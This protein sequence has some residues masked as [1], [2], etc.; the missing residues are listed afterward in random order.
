M[1]KITRPCLVPKL[2]A[3]SVFPPTPSWLSHITSFY[4]FTFQ[5]PAAGFK[6]VRGGRR[7]TCY[8]MWSLHLLPCA[9]AIDVT[10]MLKYG[11]KSFPTTIKTSLPE[12]YSISSTAT[13]NLIKF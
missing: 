13:F 6:E 9:V 2:R 4:F 8:D 12:F 7:Q 11:F 3:V 1:I 10:A 5:F